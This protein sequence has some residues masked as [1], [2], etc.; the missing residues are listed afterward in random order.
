MEL[1]EKTPDNKVN[2]SKELASGKGVI[3]GIPAAFSP[4]CNDTHIPGYINHPKIKDVGPV[5]VVAVNDA[6]W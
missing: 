4:A 5:F 3:I 1:Q 2:L 6:F